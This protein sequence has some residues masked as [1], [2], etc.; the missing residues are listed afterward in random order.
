MLAAV[1]AL[2]LVPLAV[3]LV[4]GSLRRALHAIAGV[5]SAAVVAALMA[6]R[7]LTGAIVGNLGIAGSQRPA[8]VV[9]AVVSV[10]AEQ[11]AV[12]TTALVLALTAALLRPAA[13]RGLWGL[14]G[15][16]PPSSRSSCSPRRA[17]RR[18]PSWSARGRSWASSR[19]CP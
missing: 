2:T 4:R 3:Q 7:S 8:D 16:E 12:V 1:G 11:Q 14:V 6:H 5:L 18:R 13:A 17:S 15:L 10:L 19:A 9:N